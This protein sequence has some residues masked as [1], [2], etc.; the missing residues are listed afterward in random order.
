MDKLG[1]VDSAHRLA[2]AANCRSGSRERSTPPVQQEVRDS[3]KEKI[4]RTK[5][6]QVLVAA[7]AVTLFWIPTRQDKKCW[8]ARLRQGPSLLSGGLLD[9]SWG[10]YHV[11]NWDCPLSALVKFLDVSQPQEGKQKRKEALKPR[12][13]DVDTMP[14]KR[15]TMVRVGPEREFA[16]RRSKSRQW[17]WRYVFAVAP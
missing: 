2:P 16:P 6:G 4:R 3:D 11:N 13:S 17:E 14:D 8:P 9:R 1:E 10:Q 7:V 15:R 12:L 5:T